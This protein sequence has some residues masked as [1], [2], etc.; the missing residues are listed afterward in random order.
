M[1]RLAQKLPYLT[2]LVIGDFDGTLLPVSPV[3]AFI[4]T[5]SKQWIGA[6]KI[7]PNHPRQIEVRIVDRRW[8]PQAAHDITPML[9]TM[10][11]DGL[12]FRIVPFPAF[13]QI[14]FERFDY[15]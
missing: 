6:R 5:F 15:Y 14:I 10:D 3:P 4:Q 1:L 11:K 7:F 8:G 9:L 2:T 13:P 12:F